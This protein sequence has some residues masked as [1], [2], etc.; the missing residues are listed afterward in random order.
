MRNLKRV[1]ALVMALV[2]ALSLMVM[3]VSAASY[4]DANQ[5]DDDYAEAIEILS[6]MGVFRGQDN[7]SF[8]PKAI[9]TRA[10][11]ATLVYRILTSDVDDKKVDLYDYSSFDDVKEGQWWTGYITYAANGGYVVGDGNGMF[12][13][14]DQVTGVQVLTIMLRAIGYG[15][16][17]EY[18]GAAWK[19]NVLTDAHELGLLKGI[20]TNDLDKGASRELVAQLLFNAITTPKMVTYSAL[21]GYRIDRDAQTLGQKNFYL[22]TTDAQDDWGRPSVIWFKD[23]NGDGKLGAKETKYA[24]FAE[25]PVATHTVKSSQCDIAVDLGEKKTFTLDVYTNG[26][27]EEDVSFSAT[28]TAK[29]LGAQGTLIEVYEDRLVIVDTYL[30]QVTKVTDAEYDKAGH[31]VK[32][33]YTTLKVW[34]N[35]YGKDPTTKIE[36]EGEDGY[37]KDAY[38]LVYYNAENEY[39]E[40]VAEAESFT[41]AQDMI[42]KNASKHT[43]EDEDYMDAVHFYLDEAGTDD[44]KYTWFV[45]LYGNLIGSVEI[46]ATYNYAVL[47]DIIWIVGRPGYAEATLVYM[48][49]SEETVEVAKMDGDDKFDDDF[50]Y[51]DDAVTVLKDSASVINAGD[52]SSDSKYNTMYLGYALYKIE[53]NKDGS[54]NLHGVM[55]DN[56]IPVVYYDEDANIDTSASVILDLDD[57]GKVYVTTKTEFLVREG[58]AKTGYTYAVY[59]IDTLPEYEDNCEIF[60][61]VDS[62]GIA[63]RVYIK[64]ATEEADFG[65]HLFVTTSS[66]GRVAGK[67]DTYKMT[68]LVDGVERTI[69]TN[70]DNIEILAANKGKLFHVEWVRDSYASGIYGFVDE[71]RLINE[72]EDD[73]DTFG[74]CDYLNHDVMV[75]VSSIVCG[76]ESYRFDSNTKVYGEIDSI[77]KLTQ[78]VAD[79]YGIWVIA[80]YTT[81]YGRADAVYVGTKLSDDANAL[82]NGTKCEDGVFTLTLP[83]GK[84]KM[85]ITIKVANDNTLIDADKL[86][87]G[88]ATIKDVEAGTYYFEVYA[89]DGCCSGEYKIVVEPAE[90]TYAGALDHAVM[91]SAYGAEIFV[92]VTKDGAKLPLNTTLKDR[93]V[94][95]KVYNKAGQEVYST[96]NATWTILPSDGTVMRVVGNPLFTLTQ[97]E[98]YRAVVTVTGTD[99][100]NDVS[101]TIETPFIEA[102]TSTNGPEIA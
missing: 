64:N 68:V 24:T 7:G 77:D 85:D 4:T 1:L 94:G 41:G 101:V 44:A 88:D 92:S 25:E 5:I 30:G 27:L 91:D 60:Y 75:T 45:D 8:A 56:R 53:Y 65:E 29:T 89:E 95:L 98:E 80:D 69:A 78:D 81:R 97:G 47:K 20:S 6:G 14:E 70:I 23:A 51:T 37:A 38:V 22:E 62:K 67:Y 61:T 2:M 34:D 59:D 74:G 93:T 83:K 3:G 50:W 71:V 32:D 16:N 96:L 86:Y 42:W 19:D 66:Y 63:T 58:N 87:A 15:Q 72:D 90:P 28:K 79:K 99:A 84:D 82:V 55:G 36:I 39:Y 40:I 73:D 54:V 10:E 46:A 49:G 100:G 48:D 35:G 17:G 12:R 18:V 33:L 26:V 11:A 76:G 102:Q 52:V 31:L 21:L 13:P 57:L 43:I 9:L